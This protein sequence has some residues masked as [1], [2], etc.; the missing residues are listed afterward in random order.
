MQTY[1]I[2]IEPGQIVRWI[3]AERRATPSEFRIVATRALET[4]ELPTRKEFRLGDEERENL[5]ETATVATLQIAPAD[6][7]D[8]WLLTIVIEDEI[9]PGASGEAGTAEEEQEIGVDVFYDEFIRPGRGNASAFV[10]VEEP[11]G[12]AHLARLINDIEQDRHASDR[13]ASPR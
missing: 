12:K 5:S 3:I 13:S 10:E 8:G 2:D 4:R 6:P 9:G 7:S 11:A 1:P